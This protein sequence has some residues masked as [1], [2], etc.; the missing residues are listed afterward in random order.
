[1][2]DGRSGGG[3]PSNNCFGF[4]VRYVRCTKFSAGPDQKYRSCYAQLL[5]FIGP[6]DLWSEMSP[7][8]LSIPS[9]GIVLDHVTRWR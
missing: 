4:P 9:I 5:Q 6:S 2:T 8:D 7:Q 1:M 3:G